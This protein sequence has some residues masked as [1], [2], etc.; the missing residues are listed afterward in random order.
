MTLL[1]GWHSA[2]SHHPA[3]VHFFIVLWL[4]ALAV[5]II[6]VWR[7]NDFLHR[8]SVWLLWLGTIAGT[9]AVLTG[10]YA[11]RMAPAGM[12]GLLETHKS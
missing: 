3:F 1:P 5:E 2:L 12:G 8:A 10:L 6:A 9:F 7:R 4:L 11:S